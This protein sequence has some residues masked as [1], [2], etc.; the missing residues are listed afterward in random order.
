M[1]AWPTQR[2]LH[3]FANAF[4]SEDRCSRGCQRCVAADVVD[5]NVRIH[6]VADVLV[7]G[8]GYFCDYPFAQCRVKRVN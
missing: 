1:M 3:T 6:D 7:R 4:V 5:V 8:L 2:F